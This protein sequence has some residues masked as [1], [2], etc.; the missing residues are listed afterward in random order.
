MLRLDKLSDNLLV[1]CRLIMSVVFVVEK[2]SYLRL[3]KKKR[4]TI[5]LQHVG[6]LFKFY[7]HDII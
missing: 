3:N 4:A 7:M 5:K 2:F 6:N 1:G